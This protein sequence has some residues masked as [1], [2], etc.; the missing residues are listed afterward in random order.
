LTI[1]NFHPPYVWR[2]KFIGVAKM[3]DEFENDWGDFGPAPIEVT[4]AVCSFA[5]DKTRDGGQLVRGG[6]VGFGFV[7]PG[8]RFRGDFFKDSNK[9]SLATE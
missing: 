1:E 5:K 4:L 2:I 9:K 3:T 8:P 7:G 6:P